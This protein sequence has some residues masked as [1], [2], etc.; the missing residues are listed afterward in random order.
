[1][2]NLGEVLAKWCQYITYAEFLKAAIMQSHNCVKYSRICANFGLMNVKQEKVAQNF[3]Y[4]AQ[5]NKVFLV[6]H[7]F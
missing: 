2:M 6:S 5:V 3:M 7:F 1:M 4:L